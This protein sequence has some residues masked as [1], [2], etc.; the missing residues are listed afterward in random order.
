M[1][2]S[3]TLGVAVLA[4]TFVTALI[5]A[6]PASAADRLCETNT[7][8]CASPVAANSIL[9]AEA[10]DVIFTGDTEITCASSAITLK[11]TSNTGAANPTGEVTALTWNICKDITHGV[12][13]HDEVTQNLPYHMEVTTTG[14]P[15]T[16]DLTIKPH[17]GGGSPGVTF[18]CGIFVRCIFQASDLTLPIDVGSP[19]SITA[20]DFR[21]EAVDESGI[22]CPEEVFLDAK[23]VLVSPTSSLFVSSS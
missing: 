16:P 13:C 22:P 4:A 17:S 8:P 10:T 7:T 9:K 18:L 12:S 11:V 14:S 5:G 3:K 20:N 2:Y 15:T 6:G 21:L 23:Y 19:A 1:S